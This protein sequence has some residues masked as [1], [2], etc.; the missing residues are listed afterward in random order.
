MKAAVIRALT[1]TREGLQSLKGSPKY[2][3]M[4]FETN[5]RLI[6]LA[7]KPACALQGPIYCVRYQRVRQLQLLLAVLVVYT[8]FD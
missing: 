5:C 8:I 6:G 3:H 1:Q 2:S 7:L 4:H